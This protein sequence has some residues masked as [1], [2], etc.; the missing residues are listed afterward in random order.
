MKKK[1]LVRLFIYISLGFLVYYLYKERFLTIPEIHN[2]FYLII[3]I[4]LIFLGLMFNSLQWKAVLLKNNYSIQNSDAVLSFGLTIFGKYI[5]GK[6]W[7]IVGRATYISEKTKFSLKKLTAISLNTQFISLWVGLSLGIIGV[8]YGG[9]SPLWEVL[10]SVLWLTL[11]TIIF[12]TPIHRLSEKIFLSLTKRNF[13]IPFIKFK[14]IVKI[15]PNFILTWITYAFA[16]YFLVSSLLLEKQELT[17]G[18]GFPFAGTMGIMAVFSPGGLGVRE[19]FLT[20]FLKLYD[21]STY[22]ALSISIFSRLWFLLGEIL[23]F[24]SALGLKITEKRK[25]RNGYF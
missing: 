6:L 14:D 4:V 25:E 9:G 5:P 11:S 2:T 23:I 12:V 8:I 22:N 16:F 1:I 3:S 17:I 24:L 19:G 21:I 15:L 13:T 20:G 18:L 10:S 7:M